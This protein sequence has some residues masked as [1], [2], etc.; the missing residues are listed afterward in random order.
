MEKSKVK[1]IGERNKCDKR[2]I[3]NVITQKWI[4]E[5]ILVAKIFD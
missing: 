5:P 3:I 4:L 2:L 1:L